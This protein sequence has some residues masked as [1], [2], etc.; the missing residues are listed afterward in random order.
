MVPTRGCWFLQ[1][2]FQKWPKLPMFYVG[3]QRT[4][5][6]CQ[7]GLPQQRQLSA[8]I[9]AQLQHNVLPTCLYEDPSW[10]ISIPLGYNLGSQK[11]TLKQIQHYKTHTQQT[12]KKTKS[13]IHAETRDWSCNSHGQG[14]DLPL[15]LFCF[16]KQKKENE[17]RLQAS[18]YALRDGDLLFYCCFSAVS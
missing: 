6:C 4:E 8:T 17:K 18:S 2:S 15:G 16:K 7:A 11:E 5:C 3:R 12:K 14:N 10:C 1:D 9:P 13:R